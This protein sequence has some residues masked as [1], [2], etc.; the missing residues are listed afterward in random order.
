MRVPVH[1]TYHRKKP[2]TA[3]RALKTGVRVLLGTAVLYLV[4]STFVVVSV[5]VE[6]VSM[7]PAVSPAD[8][9]L[10]APV[11]YGARI[12]WT[13]SRVPGFRP[14]ARG[15]VVL[16]ESPQAAGRSTWGEALDAVVRF[17]TLQRVSIY[18]NERGAGVSRLIVKR[19]VGLP[20]DTIRLEGYVAWIRPRDAAQFSVEGELIEASY[21]PS[22]GSATALP[23]GTPFGGD[24]GELVLGADQYFLLGDNRADSSDSRSWGPVR[25][26]R[27]VGPVVARYFP[28]HDLG[29]I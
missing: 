22:A 5:R 13:G 19:I 12:P 17:F 24:L 16:V 23:P 20:G 18:P 28:F 29:R 21:V 26:E 8:R 7:E 10:V 15:D 2:K 4:V 6:S 1:V 3:L 14:P 9:L 25:L 27:I 11:V